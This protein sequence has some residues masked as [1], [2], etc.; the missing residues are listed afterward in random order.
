M[1]PQITHLLAHFTTMTHYVLVLPYMSGGDLLALVNS[2]RTHAALCENLLARMMREL[3]LA[4][5]WMHSVSIVH[6]DIKLE[7]MHTFC[8]FLFFQNR[9][10]F[11]TISSD[12]LL[13]LSRRRGRSWTPRRW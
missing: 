11:H 7:S 10:D 6:R 12:I 1:H 8:L 13:I 5:E 2:D 9:I 4:V 3:F